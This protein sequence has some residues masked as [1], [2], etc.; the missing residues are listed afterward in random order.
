MWHNK[1]YQLQVV[2]VFGERAEDERLSYGRKKRQT[3]G[4]LGELMEKYDEMRDEVL[5]K[6]VGRFYFYKYATL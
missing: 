5:Q 6:R 3:I 2:C 4:E 1:F